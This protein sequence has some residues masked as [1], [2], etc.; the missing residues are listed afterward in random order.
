M[1]VD[2]PSAGRG[3]WVSVDGPWTRQEVEKL[4]AVLKIIVIR[5]N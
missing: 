3:S 5:E 2:E 1:C 4:D